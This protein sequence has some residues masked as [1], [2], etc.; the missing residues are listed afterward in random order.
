MKIKNKILFWFLVP[1]IVIA[2]ITA[3]FCY[4][5][6]RKTVEKDIFT[7]LEIA[8]DDSQSKILF[9]LKEKS[10]STFNFSTDG[11]IRKCAEEITMKDERIVYHTSAL[12][13]HLIINKKSLSPNIFAVFVVDL[14]G[15][16][17]ASTDEKRIGEDVSG[18]EYFSEA[19]PHIG[20]N[21]EPYYDIHSKE[22]VIDFF[23]VLLSKIGQEPVGIIVNKIKY[24][25]KED[26]GLNSASIP[27]DDD[28]G[29][30]Q[31]IAVNKAR[32]LD[33]SSDGF[34]RD[35]TV[36]IARRDKRVLYYTDLL[37]EYLER[38]KKPIDPD[39]LVEFIVDLDGNVISH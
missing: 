33:F 28:P 3:V 30:Y 14:E 1:S 38:S 37:N 24:E 27:Q 4:L 9:M 29:Y 21:T 26:K 31:L 12:N 11:F 2:T 23:T 10:R 25:Q 35:S 17:I 16:I 13:S 5:F 15:K 7:Q 32:I 39:I 18:K 22:M 20:Y 8:A 6:T 19:A 34:I 36:E